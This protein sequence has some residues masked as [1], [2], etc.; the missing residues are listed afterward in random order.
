V[1]VQIKEK[2][3]ER[4]KTDKYVKWSTKFRVFVFVN[5]MLCYDE[6]CEFML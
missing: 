4:K 1:E 5:V 3:K 2:K 6:C